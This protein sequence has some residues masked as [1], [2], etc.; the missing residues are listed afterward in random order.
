MSP[1]I[2]LAVGAS[3]GLALGGT[4]YDRLKRE[5][6]EW[7]ETFRSIWDSTCAIAVFTALVI[8]LLHPTF[9]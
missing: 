5:P 3:V 4:I 8:F 9:K 6:R 1:L 2:Q 7:G